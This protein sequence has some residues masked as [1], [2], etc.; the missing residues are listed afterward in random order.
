MGPLVG[1]L[2]H[3][4][5]WYSR[6]D[7][8]HVE[9]HV[10]LCELLADAL[11]LAADE[12]RTLVRASALHEFGRIGFDY[13]LRD[14]LVALADRKGCVDLLS[15]TELVRRGLVPDWPA[16]A[17][18]V[19]AIERALG[20]ELPRPQRRNLE[21]LFAHDQLTVE[22][23]LERRDAIP[24]DVERPLSVLRAFVALQE[25]R[26]PRA[27]DT[28]VLFAVALAGADQLE[29]TNNRRRWA[30]SRRRGRSWL[31]IHLT[32]EAIAGRDATLPSLHLH[33]IDQPAGRT[34]CYGRRVHELLVSLLRDP[35]ATL[36]TILGDARHA[37]VPAAEW[38]AV[39]EYPAVMM[40]A[41]SGTHCDASS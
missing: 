13:G 22:N 38:A 20:E 16:P 15:R 6:D 25:R 7:R 8:E 23:V 26:D 19:A 3:V 41:L 9:R 39:E 17:E 12:R 24:F 33:L 32:D 11:E 5:G 28:D 31:E 40:P 21:I 14:E 4:L 27:G 29:I 37:P 1:D 34:S 30:R 10:R 36:V 18:V 2:E 35:P